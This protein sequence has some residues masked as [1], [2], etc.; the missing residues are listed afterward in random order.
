MH[1]TAKCNKL[2]GA[3]KK[4]YLNKIYTYKT[5]ILFSYQLLCQ[6]KHIK[7]ILCIEADKKYFITTTYSNA[8]HKII[9]KI[10][11]SVEILWAKSD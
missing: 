6:K 11:I 8:Q 10:M 1:Y 2:L 9:E 3:M 4:K 5:S 7:G